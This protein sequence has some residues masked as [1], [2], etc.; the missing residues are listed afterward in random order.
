MLDNSFVQD[1]KRSV[2]E[3]F[4]GTPEA[5]RLHTVGG[6]PV[7]GS[8]G[9]EGSHLN[10]IVSKDRK[11]GTLVEA[12]EEEDQYAWE[13]KEDQH[14]AAPA[15]LRVTEQPTAGFVLPA[16]NKGPHDSFIRAT[17]QPQG[18]SIN[19]VPLTLKGDSDL[20]QLEAVKAANRQTLKALVTETRRDDVG[21]GE[22][23]FVG[24]GEE[25]NEDQIYNFEA[26]F[27]KFTDS[28][29]PL[30]NW[31]KPTFMLATF[32]AI[33]SFFV[34]FIKIDFANVMHAVAC[35]IDSCRRSSSCTWRRLS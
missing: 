23:S 13:K 20:P 28:L 4:G 26:S 29:Y 21:K 27:G 34:S 8:S 10:R 19:N 35:V 24:V 31:A 7:R 12:I 11:Y 17:A 3:F 25:P 1:V 32:I 9:N 5:P 30:E 22:A 16:T 33:V 15:G 14:P 18:L 2:P 6:G